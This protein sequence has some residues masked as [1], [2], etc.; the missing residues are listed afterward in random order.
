[1]AWKR[2]RNSMPESEALASLH[3]ARAAAVFAFGEAS[4]VIAKLAFTRDL[5]AT[6]AA[7]RMIQHAANTQHAAIGADLRYERAVA[8]EKTA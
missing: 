3:A 7:N 6:D 5:V 4:L 8:A 2:Q 1:M